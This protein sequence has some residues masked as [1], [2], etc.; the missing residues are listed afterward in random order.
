MRENVNASMKKVANR[1]DRDFG[2]EIVHEAVSRRPPSSLYTFVARNHMYTYDADVWDLSIVQGPFSVA[3]C[4]TL[5]VTIRNASLCESRGMGSNPTRLTVLRSTKE[6]TRRG[7]GGGATFMRSSIC[8][9]HVV[10]SRHGVHCPQL[11]CL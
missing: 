9:S 3:P 4:Q 2:W 11:S 10:P 8:H 1:N 7:E 5:I 6:H